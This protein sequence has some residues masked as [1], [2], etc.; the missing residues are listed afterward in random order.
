MTEYDHPRSRSE[1]DSISFRKIFIGGLSYGTD[2][3]EKWEE[4]S[5]IQRLI[6]HISSLFILWI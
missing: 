4:R 1:T 3:G 2:D 5:H 6:S